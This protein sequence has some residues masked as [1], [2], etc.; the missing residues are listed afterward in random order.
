MD[1]AVLGM[2]Q[3][4][5]ALAGRLL[6]GKH[7]VR[8]WN[9][10][11]GRTGHLVAA[12]AEEAHGI[13]EAVAGADVVVTMLADDSAVTAVAGELRSAI[14]PGTCY[15]DCSTVSPALSNR[16]AEIFVD[17]FVAMPIVGGPAA[18]RA[19][20]AML[21]VGGSAAAVDRLGPLIES[22][23][24]IVR[25]YDTAQLALTAKLAINLLLLSGIVSLAESFVV[26][27]SGGLDDDQ[28]RDLL[29]TSPV[30]APGLDNRFEGVLAGVP[31]GWWR[32]VLGAK[33]AGLAL[34]VAHAAGVALPMAAAVRNL[35]SSA[36][37]R[38]ADA[39]IAVVADLYRHT[40]TIVSGALRRSATCAI[41]NSAETTRWLS[42]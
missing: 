11:E 31:D 40:P 38:D 3:M 23:S 5:R 24:D 9:R 19:G 32:T 27:R 2:G 15:V 8:V 4:G 7:R 29:G 26:G 34:D 20:Q 30:V 13:A 16:L 17:G 6:G 1:I 28:L 25:H 37:S 12:G 10:T 22:L 36:A 39:D 18:V 35:Y 42:G 14:E 41:R 33:D 21:L